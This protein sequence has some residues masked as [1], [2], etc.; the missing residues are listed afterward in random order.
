MAVIAPREAAGAAAA[1]IQPGPLAI[2]NSAWRPAPGAGSI[3]QVSGR[4]GSLAAQLNH[5]ERLGAGCAYPRW[6]IRVHGRLGTTTA[7][8]HWRTLAPWRS[9]REIELR[10]A[11]VRQVDLS[12]IGTVDVAAE[13]W[14]QLVFTV[15]DRAR[16][17]AAL[18]ASGLVQHERPSRPGRVIAV[19]TAAE[20]DWRAP[21]ERPS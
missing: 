18:S 7:G 8:L 2:T 14:K 17:L 11:D 1:L 4:D 20:P 16:F 15:Y 5:A 3:R 6:T 9:L 12:D 21:W 13:G 10:W 19:P